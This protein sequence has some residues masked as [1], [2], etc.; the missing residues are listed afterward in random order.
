MLKNQR[1][2]A[3]REQTEEDLFDRLAEHLKN[4]TMPPEDVRKAVEGQGGPEAVNRQ[5]RFANHLK[6][7]A[8]HAEQEMDLLQVRQGIFH[9]RAVIQGRQLNEINDRILVLPPHDAAFKVKG[10]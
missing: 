5:I 2:P 8:E 3:V 7:K 4:H 10:P 6:N 9:H 1:R